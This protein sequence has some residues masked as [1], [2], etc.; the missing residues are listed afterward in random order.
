M[1]R[2]TPSA[3]TEGNAASSASVYGCRGVDRIGATTVVNPGA[4]R[5]GGWVSLTYDETTRRLTA[6]LE[7]FE[8]AVVL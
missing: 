4:L 8:R 2:G 7:R 6:R 5:D 3:C 1:L